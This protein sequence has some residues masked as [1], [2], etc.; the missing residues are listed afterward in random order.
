MNATNVTALLLWTWLHCSHDC[1][2]TA[3]MNVTALFPCCS[4][5][6]DCTVQI[7]VTALFKWMWL[8]CSNECDCT[9]PVNVIALFQWT[10]WT[11]L[12]CSP[13]YDC[14]VP[15][16]AWMRL[17]CS[18]ECDYTVPMNVTAL[19]PW[20]W[21]TRC[22]TC[23]DCC[24]Y[25]TTLWVQPTKSLRTVGVAAF[26]FGFKCSDEAST[27]KQFVKVIKDVCLKT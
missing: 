26:S 14:T 24:V 9:V 17:H 1:D 4:H 21:R 20:M 7:N 5:E 23:G 13:E 27:T 12:K 11:W 6:C 10:P 19:F 18:R 2:C 25:T 8:H 3:P 22:N 16:N 15:V